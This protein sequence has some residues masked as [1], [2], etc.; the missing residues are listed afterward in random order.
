MESNPTDAI[1]GLQLLKEFVQA[2]FSIDVDPV[3]GAV[4]GHKE[5][6]LDAIRGEFLGLGYYFLDRFG[7]MLAAH[8]GNG[9]K[10]AKPIASFGDL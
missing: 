6:L 3:I 1:D 10:G 7:D 5:Q 4:L 2:W 8:G 9:A